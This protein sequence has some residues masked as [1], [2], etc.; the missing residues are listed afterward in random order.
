M[1]AAPQ[2]RRVAVTGIGVVTP[3]GVGRETFWRALLAGESGIAPV[4]SFDTSRF[5]VHLGAEVRG[6]DAAP[7]CRKLRP[8]ELGRASQMAVAAA[9]MALA[10]AGLAPETLDPERT[11]VAMGTTSGEPLEI[12]QFND[13]FFG[14]GRDALDGAL[15]TRYPCHR[16]PGQVAAELGFAGVN[17]MLPNACAAGNYAV[18]F[19]RDALRGGRADVMLAGGADSF[20]RITYTG[21]ARLGAI[22]TDCCAPFDGERK[23]MV[24]GEGAGVLVLET[25]E[26]ARARGARIYAEVVGYGLSCDAHHMTASHPEGEGPA[27]AMAQ[28]L[29]DAGLAPE[30]VDYISAHGTGT[31]TN[32]KLETL[33]V[34]RAFGDVAKRV[35]MSS[36]KS[37]L[38][39]TMG[40][41]SALE[42]AVCCLAIADGRVPPTINYRHPDPE[43]D[44]D[45]VPNEAREVPVR[46]AMNN[47]YAFGGANASVLFAAAAE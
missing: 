9:R 22:T 13:T 30:D 12:E 19:A 18:A 11:G 46:V 34:K 33:A 6:F 37:M 14:A 7:W 31:P 42:A 43:C 21:F 47:A 4:T 25:L 28:A 39:H 17:V 44:L 20:S 38:G 2:P 45:Y 23:G 10:D 29:A 15:A 5:K 41:A 26:G 36:V 27:R 32:D 3:L 16:I 35:P 1:T 40:A 24:P 8:E